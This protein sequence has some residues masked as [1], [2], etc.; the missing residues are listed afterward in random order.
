MIIQFLL[1][2]LDFP[3]VTVMLRISLP[4]QQMHYQSIQ[5][6]SGLITCQKVNRIMNSD[7]I[8]SM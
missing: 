7:F 2:P 4:N 1:S 3:S 8:A 6:T 5:V